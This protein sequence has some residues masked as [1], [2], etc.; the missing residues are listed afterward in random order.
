MTIKHDNG[1][2]T[3]YIFEVVEK[4]PA[5]FEVWNIGGLGEY[6]PICQSIRPDD[7]NC[8]DVNTSTLKAI[9]LNKEEVT[10]LNK[11]AGSG[12]KSVKSAKSTLNRVAKTSMMKRK[13]MFAEKALPI[14]ERITA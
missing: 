11:A 2:G 6:I 7:K 13:Q 4:I 10:I 3:T 8:H 5:G 9:K 14:L 1:Y 12:V